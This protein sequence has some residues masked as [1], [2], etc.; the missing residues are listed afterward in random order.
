MRLITSQIKLKKIIVFYKKKKLF[1][2][3]YNKVTLLYIV[4]LKIF[5]IICV[6][7]KYMIRMLIEKILEKHDNKICHISLIDF[8]NLLTMK[9]L[10]S[11]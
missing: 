8:S 6:C 4:R 10:F 1:F 11:L 3:G 7:N 9:S 2:V 5:R